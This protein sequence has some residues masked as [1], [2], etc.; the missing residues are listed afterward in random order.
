MH[1]G[2][3]HHCLVTWDSPLHVADCAQE[4]SFLYADGNK[5]T[6]NAVGGT[7]EP[8]WPTEISPRG[9]LVIAAVKNLEDYINEIIVLE[10][11]V[12]GV[13]LGATA[14]MPPPPDP[15]QYRSP[16]QIV[17]GNVVWVGAADVVQMA[18]APPLA[19]FSLDGAARYLG[20]LDNMIFQDKW[21]KDYTSADL[22]GEQYLPRY[23]TYRPSEGD[24]PNLLSGGFKALVFTKHTQALDWGRPIRVVAYDVTAWKTV[25]TGTQLRDVDS[26]STTST[27]AGK[28]FF[29]F[30][31]M[32]TTAPA[33]P[34][35]N[36]STAVSNLPPLTQTYDP[37]T[38][39]A[40][41]SAWT[42][43]LNSS[44]GTPYNAVA[45]GYLIPTREAGGRGGFLTK[46]VSGAAAGPNEYTLYAIEMYPFA[47]AQT[48]PRMAPVVDDV[49]V[50][51]LRWDTGTIIEEEEVVDS[52]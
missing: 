52:D 51:Y 36:G 37:N 42:P 19:A 6:G 20:L 11:A 21:K 2:T 5:I 50:V 35:P 3:W 16:V 22:N 47:E 1:T 15:E 40:P 18:D 32:D 46:G 24:N 30:G 14:P 13:K 26:G 17:P 10:T 43:R 25:G 41:P 44:T 7:G 23:D 27:D 12:G 8:P 49:N 9:Q 39:D 38:A 45:S 33:P 31:F 4:H 28:V 34:T 29:R 48:G